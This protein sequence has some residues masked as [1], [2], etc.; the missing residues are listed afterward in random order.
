MDRN[1]FKEAK[2]VEKGTKAA[3]STHGWLSHV[4]NWRPRQHMTETPPFN[5][6]YNTWRAHV[7]KNGVHIMGLICMTMHAL[8]KYTFI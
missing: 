7:W 8:D 4:F 2:G 1:A 3:A 6:N 5:N